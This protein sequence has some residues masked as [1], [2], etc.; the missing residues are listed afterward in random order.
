MTAK[1]ETIY[2]PATLIG[3][4]GLSVFRVS[5]PKAFE[6]LSL[7]LGRELEVKPRTSFV[8]K[9][10][11]PDTRL[12]IDEGLIL[13]FK[14]PHSFTG[15]D[16]VEYHLHG[17]HAVAQS[18]L[19]AMAHMFDHRLAE[20]GEFTK[21]AFEHGRLDLTQAEAVADLIHA[22][23]EAQ[24]LL[25][26][27][28]LEGRLG[29][30]YQNWAERL[31][32]ALAYLE[33]DIDFGDDEELSDDL[34]ATV[35]PLIKEIAGSMETH[36]ND[37]SRGERLRDGLKVAII[38]APNAGK[39]SLVNALAKRDV[40]IVTDIEGTT[41]D[42]V[43][44][45]LN[46]GGYPAIIADTAGLR[47]TDDIVE[48]E[49]IKRAR[50]WAEDADLKIALFDSRNKPDETTLAMI[51]AGTIILSSHSDEATPHAMIAEKEAMPLSL[52]KA[53][54]VQALVDLLKRTAQNI[55]MKNVSRETKDDMPLITR[56]RHRAF[57]TTALEHLKR[58]ENAPSQD[59]MA[60]DVR[61][62]MRTLGKITGH[63]DV[64]DLL[65]LIF[66]DFCI[67]K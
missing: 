58:A 49:G 22:E 42:V 28:Q 8:A 3:P 62:A 63:V 36:L 32:K 44:V 60:E 47:E 11:H 53:E 9:L 13:P 23:T 7:L 1:N 41:R 55:F 37:D 48:G 12:V 17:G 56:A 15:E 14:G 26:L 35:T 43:E 4:A 65:D 52:K 59:M 19:S 33:A 20:P 24:R 51:D 21:R 40:A 54:T 45:H 30:L 25:A 27:D 29:A 66:D 18:F 50:A 57:V 64:E 6:S 38:G 31:K 61:L 5:G 10:I 46:L 2:A 67:G 34:M 39:S 16:V